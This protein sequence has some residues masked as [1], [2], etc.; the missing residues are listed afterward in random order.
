MT[1]AHCTCRFML[2]HGQHRTWGIMCFCDFQKTVGPKVFCSQTHPNKEQTHL[3]TNSD[4]TKGC[5]PASNPT[6]WA[7]LSNT[8]TQSNPSEHTHQHLVDAHAHPHW[9]SETDWDPDDCV[10][11]EPPFDQWMNT[12]FLCIKNATMDCQWH[13]CYFPIPFCLMTGWQSAHLQT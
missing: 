9:D 2:F 7:S 5:M 4:A 13:K 10:E 3:Q 8:H 11:E 12:V 6:T 1:A